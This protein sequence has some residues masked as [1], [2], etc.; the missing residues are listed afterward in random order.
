VSDTTAAGITLLGDTKVVAITPAAVEVSGDGA[1]GPITA[2][3]VITSAR[4]GG[5]PAFATELRASGISTF[6][7]GDAADPR[8]FAGITRDA[9]DLARA[10][11]V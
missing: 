2:A 10:L 11:A 7:V 6:V 4:V 3:A 8:G 9:E 1:A 5:E